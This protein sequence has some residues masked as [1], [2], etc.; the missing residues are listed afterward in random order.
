VANLACIGHAIPSRVTMDYLGDQFLLQ[1]RTEKFRNIS[2]ANFINIMSVMRARTDAD[3]A[4][5]LATFDAKRKFA[6][7]KAMIYPFPQR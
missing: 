4:E 2:F 6:A 5:R 1:C 3:R 7:D